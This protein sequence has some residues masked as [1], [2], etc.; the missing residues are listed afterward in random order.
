MDTPR[1]SSASARHISVD[2]SLIAI[3]VVAVALL[4][5]A[6]WSARG[7]SMCRARRSA[8]GAGVLGT[9]ET[10]VAFEDFSFGAQGWTSTADRASTKAMPVFGPFDVGA[11]GK[12]FALPMDTARV[13]IGVRH[14][15]AR[16]RGGRVLCPRQRPKRDRR[17]LALNTSNAVVDTAGPTGPTPCGSCSTVP[18]TP[19]SL[20]VEASPGR[21]PPGRSTTSP[22]S[23]PGGRPSPAQGPSTAGCCRSACRRRWSRGSRRRASGSGWIDAA[24]R[25]SGRIRSGHRCPNPSG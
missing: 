22:S 4:L 16:C 2:W 5:V 12:S 3:T 20:E 24:P 15:P 21:T 8:P 11:V 25:G 10:L 1:I 19:S 7:P 17:R 14:A 23:P 9:H 13:R 6:Q 18:A